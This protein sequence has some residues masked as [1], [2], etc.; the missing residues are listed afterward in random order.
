[1]VA[2]AKAAS[3]AMAF[4][5]SAATTLAGGADTAGKVTVVVS[6]LESP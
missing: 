3:A 4:A 6:R 1:M 5:C 2:A